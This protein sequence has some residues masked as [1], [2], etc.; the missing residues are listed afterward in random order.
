[1]ISAAHNKDDLDKGLEAFAQVGR[2]LGFI[3]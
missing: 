3:V 1:M 2:K